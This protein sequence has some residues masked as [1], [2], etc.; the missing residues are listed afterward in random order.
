MAELT[1]PCDN[2]ALARFLGS[3]GSVFCVSQNRAKSIDEHNRE[4]YRHRSPF[5]FRKQTQ[6][7]KVEE[8]GTCSSPKQRVIVR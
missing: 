7:L 8:G 3:T 2:C 1:S 5:D 4:V 6:R